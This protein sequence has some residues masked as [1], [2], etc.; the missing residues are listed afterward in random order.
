MSM[1]AVIGLIAGNGKMPIILAQAIRKAGHRVVAIGHLEETRK[2]LARYVNTFYWVHIGELGKIIDLLLAAKV[3]RAVLAGKVPKTHFFSK[4]KPDLRAIQVLSRLTAKNDDAILRAI[5]QE[6]ESE[7]I[8]IESPAVFLRENLVARGVLTERKPTER[9]KKD[10][11]FGW[12]MAK[13]IGALDLGQSVVVKD[14]MIL[15]VETLEGTDETIRR[16][17][18]LGRRDVLVIKVAKPKQDLRLDLPVIG[19]RTIR[20][21]RE[22]GAS[23]LAMEA[24]KTIIID[25]E[26]VVKEA[27]K[28][29]LCLMGI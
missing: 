20:T 28:H 17:G 16:G 14:Q 29:K 11:A 21:L 22:A 2:D 18:R 8:R 25:R 27:D 23:T 24:Q 7:G 6:I 1:K 4:A 19:R 9:E 3:K 13:K 26:K 15:A 5:A 12:K 10:L